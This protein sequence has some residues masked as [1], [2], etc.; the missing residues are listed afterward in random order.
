M[1]VLPPDPTL[2]DA[3]EVTLCEVWPRDGIQGWS[4]TVSTDDKLAVIAAALASGVSEVDATSFVSPK[5]TTQ[6]GDAEELLVR[7]HEAGLKATVRVLTVNTRSFDRIAANPLLRETID[8]CGFPISASEAH[9]LANLRRS[10][11]DHLEALARMIDRCADLALTPLFCVATAYGCPLEGVVARE[12]VLELAR[13][14][15]DRGVRT[16]MLGDTTGMADP[17]HAWELFTLL[18]RELPEARLVGHFHDTRGSGI[19]N[20]LAAIAAGVRVVDASLG[21]L[22]GEPPSV[23]QNHSGESGNVCTEDLV[24]VLQRMG[25]RTGIDL[26]LLLDAGRLVERVCGTTLRSQVLRT[27]PAVPAR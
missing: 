21:G 24:A 20:T 4:S 22:G 19:A 18:G 10:H 14:A 2:I 16:I 7:M 23:E 1:T 13:W 25:Y 6:F 17:R 15:Y 12:R 5:A 27:G 3:A 8:I 11:A 26:D 9:N